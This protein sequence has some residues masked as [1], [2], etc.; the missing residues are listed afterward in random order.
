[1]DIVFALITAVAYG[2]DIYFVRKGLLESPFPIKVVIVNPHCHELFSRDP[3]T[4]LFTA[5]QSGA[6]EFKNCCRYDSDRWRCHIAL[7]Y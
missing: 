7:S 5:S 6:I 4:K 1:M 2:L 3:P